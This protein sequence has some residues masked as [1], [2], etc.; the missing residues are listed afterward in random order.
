ME[1]ERIPLAVIL[2]CIFGALW[3][4][5]AA[6]IRAFCAGDRMTDPFATEAEGMR[7]IGILGKD[8]TMRWIAAAISLAF[9]ALEAWFVYMAGSSWMVSGIGGWQ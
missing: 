6:N 5:H 4:M 3:L 9:M 2:A 8:V 7:G 1:D